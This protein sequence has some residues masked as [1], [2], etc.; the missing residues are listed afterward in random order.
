MI[1]SSM[2]STRSIFRTGLAALV[3]H[4]IAPT[5][6]AWGADPYHVPSRENGSC[7]PF[8]SKPSRQDVADM[9]KYFP[10]KKYR[11]FPAHL[12]RMFQCAE[13][14]QDTCGGLPAANAS[15]DI[16]KM[17]SCNRAQRAYFL[18]AQKGWCWGGSIT[19]SEQHWIKCGSSPENKKP[20]QSY[21]GDAFTTQDFRRALR[22]LHPHGPL[23]P[24]CPI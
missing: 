18:L 2:H 5:A 9:K 4:F 1:G 11:K 23:P 24:V 12:R 13:S 8:L 15:D 6:Y 20:G 17:Q 22:E 7:G 3:L 10:L 21:E 19:S 16:I 14:E